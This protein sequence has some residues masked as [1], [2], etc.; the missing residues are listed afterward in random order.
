[1]WRLT[2]EQI[3]AFVQVY[4]KVGHFDVELKVFFHW[5]DVIEDVVDNPENKENLF[6]ILPL[7]LYEIPWYDSLHV[8][9]INDSLHG[10]GFPTRGLAVRKDGSV[11][12]GEHICKAQLQDNC[13]A[14]Y[15][16][17]DDKPLT[18]L[19]AVES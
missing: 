1:M 17:L 2:V 8:W 5:I 3:S 7:C 12:S 10:V 4:L 15:F 6:E 11:I 16:D 13:S 14:R 19:L 18:M 9:V